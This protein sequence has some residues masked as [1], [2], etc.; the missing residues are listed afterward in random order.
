M[1]ESLKHIMGAFSNLEE[2][3]TSN[4]DSMRSRAYSAVDMEYFNNGHESSRIAQ[5]RYEIKLE[6]TKRLSRLNLF[7]MNTSRFMDYLVEINIGKT[8]RF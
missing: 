5:Q 7:T 1:K 3:N 2:L 4:T 8:I 6:D